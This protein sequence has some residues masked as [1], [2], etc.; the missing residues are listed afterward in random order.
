MIEKSFKTLFLN[1]AAFIGGVAVI[2]VPLCIYFALNGAF[3]DFMYGTFLFNLLY[4]GNGTWERIF[5]NKKFVLWLCMCVFLGV[6]GGVCH[7][8][9]KGKSLRERIFGGGM[10]CVTVLAALA[11]CM[12]KRA[13]QHYLL[14]GAPIFALGLAMVCRRFVPYLSGKRW[15][16]AAAAVLTAVVFV[17]G[18]RQALGLYSELLAY[19]PTHDAA[20][21]QIVAL[22]AEIP[23]EDRDSVWAYNVDASWYVYSRI[24]PCFRNFALQDWMSVSDPEITDNILT[25]LDENPPKWIVAL[26]R[27]VF[28]K[29]EVMRKITE[30]YEIASQNETERLY[31]RK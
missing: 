7:L 8:F 9:G 23:L 30:K 17:C 20:K 24:N 18:C 21:A 4:S 12:A 10:V 1:M 6:A 31:R 22:S 15:S 11:E 26:N 2:S 16:R 5:A 19:K 13:F 29:P 25:M 14:I 28:G 27:D 3:Y